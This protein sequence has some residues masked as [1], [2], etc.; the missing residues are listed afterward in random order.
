MTR[1]TGETYPAIAH[2]FRGPDSPR[3]ALGGPTEEALS[4]PLSQTPDNRDIAA[5]RVAYARE[6]SKQWASRL[7][8]DECGVISWLSQ[9]GQAALTA[10]SFGIEYP[11]GS[12]RPLY[13]FSLETVDRA[14]STLARAMDKAPTSETA[15]V[16]YRGLRNVPVAWWLGT[17]VGDRLNIRHFSASTLSPRV[18]ADR[19]GQV[20]MDSMDLE[21]GHEPERAVLELRTKTAAFTGAVIAKADGCT[22]WNASEEEILIDARVNWQVVNAFDT[23]HY[24]GFS[25][26]R[27]RVLQ[28]D[29][30][31]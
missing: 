15:F 30:L 27:T 31:T 24:G 9:D 1:K 21:P 10:H 3:F 28:A 11:G 20:F 29:A 4:N 5:E 16:T 18:A 14:L 23:L 6:F 22:E 7:S 2:Q 19:F 17:E 12:I 26:V 8:T 25:D 13:G